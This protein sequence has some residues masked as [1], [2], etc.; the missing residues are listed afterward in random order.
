FT[1]APLF[2]DPAGSIGDFTVPDG[3]APVDVQRGYFEV[4]AEEA[5]NCEPVDAPVVRTGNFWNRLCE[6]GRCSEATPTNALSAEVILIRVMAGV[7]ELY[8]AEAVTRFRIADSGG[9]FT[10]LGTE[11]PTVRSCS[12]PDNSG[13]PNYSGTDCVNQM[14]FLL[15]KSRLTPQYDVQ[16]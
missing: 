2:A 15:S 6:G 8:N 5:V 4:I 10:P 7:S 12:G 14:N 1:T 13:G 16:N 11:A 3:L 9:A